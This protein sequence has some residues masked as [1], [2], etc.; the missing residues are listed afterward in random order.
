MKPARS[1]HL[2]CVMVAVG[3]LSPAVRAQEIGSLVVR[4]EGVPVP[5]NRVVAIVVDESI[6]VPPTAAVALRA[7]SVP[8]AVGRGLDIAAID[9]QMIFSGEVV[10]IERFERSADR[11]TL[12]VRAHDRLHRLNREKQ[13][14]TFTN[15]S[16]ADIARQLASFAGLRAEAAGPEASTPNSTVHQ[17]DQTDF[18]FL[19][20]RAAAI[21]YDIFTDGA[22]LHFEKRR[23]VP[24]IVGCRL[25]DI[26][27]R[28]LLAW[29]ASPKE[30]QQVNARGWDPVNKQEI[31]GIAQ[32]NVIRLSRVASQ[33]EPPA[34]VI[35]LG[36]IEAL[37]TAA[38]THAAAAGVLSAR[39]AHDLSAE[40][41]VDGN[42][43][44]RARA[45][46][47]LEGIGDAFNGKYFVQGVSHRLP[48]YGGGWQTLLRVL[49]ED[50]SVYLLP[51]IGDEVL[52]TFQHGDVRRP[53]VVGSLWSSPPP[54]D[55]SPC[56]R[57][58]DPV[59]VP[60]DRSR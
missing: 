14:R 37:N 26:R 44:L 13:T 6:M 16:D 11:S 55:S 60:G 47:V 53:V 12:I 29:L 56:R 52:V 9:G 8:P 18:E 43:A 59:P 32:Q 51:E 2:V 10:G 42:A 35:E 58:D 38:V 19:R 39:T 34:S 28:A 7:E 50:R 33:I 27:V 22:T 4:I 3:V 17:Q 1:H 5:S 57:R 40:M 23:L 20:E 36:F 30:V 31:I 41:A 25:E 48:G 46:I 54:P 24:Q 45:E 21:G 49:R 15:M